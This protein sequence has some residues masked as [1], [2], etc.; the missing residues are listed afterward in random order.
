MIAIVLLIAFTVAVG[1]ILSLW[2]TSFTT[3]TTGAVETVS[4]NQTK[5]FGTYIDIVSVTDTAVI[6][7]NRGSQTIE[8]VKCFAANGTIVGVLNGTVTEDALSVGSMLSSEFW[9]SSFDATTTYDSGYGASVL[10]TGSCLNI[11]V[12]GECKSDQSC[13]RI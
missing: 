3:T 2:L 13:W 7:T 6:I 4:T 12:T 10:C 5:C 1:G 11:G 8:G 9:N